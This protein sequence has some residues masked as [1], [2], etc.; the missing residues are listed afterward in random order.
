[1]RAKAFAVAVPPLLDTLHEASQS[2]ISTSKESLPHS[3][4]SHQDVHA[5]ESTM[6]KEPVHR[7]SIT[8]FGRFEVKCAGKPIM[9]CPSRSGQGILRY[10]V[11]KAEHSATSDTLQSLCWPEDETEVAQRKLHNAVS[12]L[13]RSLNES[14]PLEAGEEYIVCKNHVYSLIPTTFC[15]DVDAFL[16]Y[17][18]LGLR[19]TEERVASYEKACWLYK[20]SFLPEDRYADWSFL[21]REQFSRIYLTMCKVLSTHYLKVQQYEYAEQYA[22]AMLKEDRG[23]EVA[24]RHLMQTYAAQ[25]CRSEVRQQYQL[26]ERILREEFGVQP[27]PETQALFHTLMTNNTP[28]L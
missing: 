4:A 11:A 26:C 5:S 7:L 22:M 24:H 28:S 12:A 13:R 18:Q 9:L 3:V 15:T 8:C 19:N 6:L 14:V 16:H 27:L 2:I 10:L 21:Q 17:H 25:G 23:D 20:G 1:M